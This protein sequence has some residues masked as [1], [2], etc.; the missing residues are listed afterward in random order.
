M[1]MMHC[2]NCDHIRDTDFETECPVCLAPSLDELQAACEGIRKQL[3]VIRE[4]QYYAC[5]SDNFA[6][7]NGTF[8]SYQKRIRALQKALRETE[9]E[10]ERLYA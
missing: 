7:T 5:L 3:E 2:K 10:A 9:A 6:Y 4:D 8:E 1:S